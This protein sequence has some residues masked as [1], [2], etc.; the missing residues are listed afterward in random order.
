MKYCTIA[1][2]GWLCPGSVC[3]QV[4]P[5]A[6][7]TTVPQRSAGPLRSATVA[8]PIAGASGSGA[9]P[10]CSTSYRSRSTPQPI[11]AGTGQTRR[12]AS[13]RHC[14]ATR[15]RASHAGCMLGLVGQ[16]G[17]Q[18]QYRQAQGE[19]ACPGPRPG[20]AAAAPRTRPRRGPAAR[21]GGPAAARRSTRPLR[22]R[23]ATPGA[24]AESGVVPGAVCVT[25]R[26]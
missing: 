10:N 2:Y 20:P 3:D 1:S 5:A 6:S 19:R 24:P 15:S 13:G 7:P 11:S 9:Y 25:S 4:T 16:Q 8:K 22:E 14:P 18:V 12:S 17:Q 26:S 21:R 23:P